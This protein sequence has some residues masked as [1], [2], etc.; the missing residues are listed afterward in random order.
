MGFDGFWWVLMGSDGFWWVLMGSDG[1]WWVLM[2]FICERISLGSFRFS[3]N[4]P[5]RSAVRP[6]RRMRPVSR[7]GCRKWTMIASDWGKCGLFSWRWRIDPAAGRRTRRIPRRNDV[8]AAVN[9]RTGNSAPV[10]RATGGF[11]SPIGAPLRLRRRASS[12]VDQ[13]QR[14]A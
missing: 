6:R 2:G 4:A 14:P 13:L 8:E 1:F 12:A 7:R 3:G 10:T 9:W 11:S 5:P